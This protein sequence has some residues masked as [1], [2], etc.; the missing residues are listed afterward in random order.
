MG[1]VKALSLGRIFIV[2]FPAQV[3]QDQLLESCLQLLAVEILHH[4]VL[5]R[6]TTFHHRF[7]DRSREVAQQS[8]LWRVIADLI[9]HLLVLAEFV[10]DCVEPVDQV[11]I[12]K[13]VCD[14]QII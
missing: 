5:L 13:P 4:L 2:Y 12:C 8:L 1:I 3:L 10:A 7:V 14:E 11:S 9:H 6:L